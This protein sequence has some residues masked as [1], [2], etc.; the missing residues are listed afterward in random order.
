M[1]P[2]LW[3]FPLF[4]LLLLTAIRI[5]TAGSVPQV[6]AEAWWLGFWAD[7]IALVMIGAL[8]GLIGHIAAER[9]R[10]ILS[11]VVI[12]IVLVIAIAE[13]FFWHEFEARLDRLVFHYLA[14]PVEVLTFLEEQFYIKWILI[15]FVLVVALL[16][17][18][19]GTPPEPSIRAT[20]LMLCAALVAGW[21]SSQP[22]I[23]QSRL[24]TQ[25]ASN[26]YV[27]ALTAARMDQKHW[28][29]LYPGIAA[30]NAGFE[31]AEAVPSQVKVDA[32][33][34]ILI[35]EESFAGKT[36]EDPQQRAVHLPSFTALEKQGLSFSNVYAAGTRTTRGMES[37][38]HGFPPLPG[39][40]ATEREG[41]DRLPSLPRVFR[42]S[43]YM[44]VFAYGGWPDFSN[45]TTYWRGIGFEKTTS[46][47]DFPY[48]LFETSWG[49]SDRDLFAHVL[50]MMDELTTDPRPVFLSTLTVSNHRPFVVPEGEPG[51]EE[52]S[53]RA[54]MHYADAALGWFFTQARLRPW[55][56]DTVFVVVA[57]H[58]PRIHGDS[59][60]PVESYRV[61]LLL[62]SNPEV[63]PA[64]VKEQGSTSGLPA[65]LLSLLDMPSKE[66]FWAPSLIDGK[67]DPVLVEHDYHVGELTVDGLT[68]LARGG[69][70]YRWR[71]RQG[72]LEPEGALSQDDPAARRIS[73]VFSQA[74]AQLYP[75]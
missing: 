34:V 32:K 48:G 12:A 53:L 41:F 16:V 71:W 27:G 33:H 40:S 50:V 19:T 6:P 26:G 72:G 68:V 58:G 73:D 49:V 52:R 15:P 17:R 59:L 21:V 69:Q 25:L 54:A 43:G 29:G 38:M 62:I 13:V 31:P 5:H 42:H 51:S 74:H 20:L 44:T 36:W 30:A 4:F 46:R 64:V 39:I 14:Y 70:F 10:N 63:E 24:L 61:P 7:L 55:F 22:V 3:R 45:F 11:G 35:I 8:Y 47:Y 56:D 60:I 67:D 75:R 37:I 28:A 9:G 18:I 65:T 57:D 2:F 23:Q 1:T 66:I